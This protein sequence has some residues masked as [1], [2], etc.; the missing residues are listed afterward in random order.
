MNVLPSAFRVRR[1][2]RQPGQADSVLALEWLGGE[3]LVAPLPALER[4]ARP[5]SVPAARVDDVAPDWC[6]I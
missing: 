2:A 1:A 5:R 4:E 3:A 6:V